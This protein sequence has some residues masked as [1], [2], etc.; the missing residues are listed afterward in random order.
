ML[1]LSA[2]F[3]RGIG[4]GDGGGTRQSFGGFGDTTGA[5]ESNNVEPRYSCQR[6]FAYSLCLFILII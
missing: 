1:W 3:G 2:G 4:T 5:V 6:L